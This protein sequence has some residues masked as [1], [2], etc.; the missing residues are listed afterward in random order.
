MA[1][2]IGFIGTGTIGLPT[3][4]SPI[5]KLSIASKDVSLA[6]ASAEKL[7][8]SV[9]VTRAAA[10]LYAAAEASGLGDEAFFAT[11]EQIERES[12]VQVPPVTG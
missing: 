12:G 1:E 10:E 3:F 2:A 9:R 11:L 8:V 7:G 6:V 5:F 4:D